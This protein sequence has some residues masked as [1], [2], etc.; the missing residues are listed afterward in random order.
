MSDDKMDVFK[1]DFALII[2]AGFVAVKQMDE[3]SATRI[4]Q[5]AQA[6]SPRN[7]APR[8]GIGYIALNKLEL[9]QATQIFEE[10]TQQEPD[11]LL[12]RTFY[13][14][15][16]LLTRGKQKKGEKI[17]REVIESTTDVT[18]KNLAVVSLEWSEKELQKISNTPFFTNQPI[19][20]E[21]END[22]KE[23]VKKDS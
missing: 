1:E 7:T 12:A 14:M 11:N 5:A 22:L 23:D 20:S 9:K 19:P 15:C 4:F 8:I 17:I 6:I 10:V 18:I 13:G 3:V 21:E 16:F 2:E